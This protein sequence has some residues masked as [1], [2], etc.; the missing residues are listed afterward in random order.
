MRKSS[1]SRLMTPSRVHERFGFFSDSRYPFTAG[2]GLRGGAKVEDGGWR[3]EDGGAQRGTKSGASARPTPRGSKSA[4]ASP[5]PSVP[6]PR[7]G[8][9]RT[10]RRAR[11][12]ARFQPVAD[13]GLPALCALGGNLC[14]RAVTRFFPPNAFSHGSGLSFSGDADTILAG[15]KIERAK[16]E[17]ACC[18]EAK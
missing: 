12:Q 17:C 4:D 11:P 10:E 5:S 14:P 3:I 6:L 13:Q 9:G 7:R 18:G 1:M 16:N 15:A 2:E 8:E